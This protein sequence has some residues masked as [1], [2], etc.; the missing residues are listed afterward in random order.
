DVATFAFP[1]EVLVKTRAGT[2]ETHRKI[3]TETADTLVVALAERPRFVVLD[4]EMSVTTSVKLEAPADFLRAQLEQGPAAAARWQAA[5]A[6]AERD[7]LRSVEALA[8]ALGRTK[9]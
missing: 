6:L 9:E 5:R 7:D 8:A 2:L 4:P 3:V 1:L